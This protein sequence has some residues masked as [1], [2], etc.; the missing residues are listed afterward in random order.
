[1]DRAWQDVKQQEQSHTVM[2]YTVVPQPFPSELCLSKL[3]VFR[4]LVGPVPHLC[5]LLRN[6]AAA[7]MPFSTGADTPLL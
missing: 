7:F 6:T 5:G 3:P 4:A 2:Q 1:M